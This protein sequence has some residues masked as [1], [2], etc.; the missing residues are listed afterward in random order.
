MLES[1]AQLDDTSQLLTFWLAVTVG[2]LLLFP[3]VW[4]SPAV[5]SVPILLG[6][7]GAVTLL[8]LPV[9]KGAWIGLMYALGLK[10]GDAALHTA[11]AVD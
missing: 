9:V 1:F 8:A 11:D 3:I 10:A 2:L 4:E 7:L 5:F 6:A